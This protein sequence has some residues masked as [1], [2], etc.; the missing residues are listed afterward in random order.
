MYALDGS[1]LL[2]CTPQ[3]AFVK[4]LEFGNPSNG[5]GGGGGGGGD[6]GHQYMAPNPE[7]S[8]KVEGVVAR[9]CRVGY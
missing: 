9:P 5:G 3:L 4:I 2:I 6:G 1:Q 7:N 8:P